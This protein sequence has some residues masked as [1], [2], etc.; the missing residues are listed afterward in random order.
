MPTTVTNGA[1]LQCTFGFT[2][3]PLTVIPTSRVSASKMSAATVLDNKPMVNIKPFGMCSAPSNPAVI[4][5]TSAALG[6]FTPAPCIPNTITPWVPGSATVKAGMVPVINNT[7]KLN[8]LWGGLISVTMPGQF[9]VN[10]S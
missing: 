9:T 10:N 7:C 6:V 1:I 5:A 8:C 2:P 4:A 3:S